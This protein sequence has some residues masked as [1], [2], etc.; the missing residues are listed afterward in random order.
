MD[1]VIVV[2]GASAGLG[3]AVTREIARRGA[4]VGLLAR[5]EQRLETTLEEVRE[6]GSDGVAIPTDVADPD[7]VERAAV[8]VE[9]ALGPIDVWINNAMVTVLSRLIDLTPDELRRVTEVDY[10]GSVWGTQAALRRMMPRDRG[11]IIQIGSAL[12]YRGIPL[13]AAYCGAKHAM[14]GLTDSLRAEL[15]HARSS[16]HVTMLQMPA[17]NTPQFSW[18]RT[19][20]E[21]HPQPVPP[22][23]QPE[24]AARAVADAIGSRRREIYVGLP[25]WKTVFGSKVVP[26][27]ADRVLAHEG[28]DG[29]QVPDRPFDPDRPD[30]LFEPVEGDWAAHGVFDEQAKS[31]SIQARITRWWTALRRAIGRLFGHEPPTPA[32]KSGS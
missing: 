13:Q 1:Q 24:V 10:L 11:Q 2:T 22:I 28:F 8:R 25:T 15:R 30:N 16:V 26:G 23:F 5:G 7:A 20:M 29:Q 9:E 14:R 21:H 3:R 4:R 27:V 17:M 12:A 6:L 32:L 19:R 31:R 18:G